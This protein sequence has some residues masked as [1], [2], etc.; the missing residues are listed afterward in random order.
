MLKIIAS[1]YGGSVIHVNSSSG[2]YVQ[3]VINNSFTIRTVILPLLNKYP[4][5]TSR[6]SLQLAFLIKAINGIT[7]KEY[8]DLRQSKY[9]NQDLFMPSFTLD[10]LPY[11]FSPWLGG[12]IEGK[13]CFL[14][15]SG[16]NIMNFSI[17]QL[18]DFYL[19]EAIR[20]YFDVEDLKISRK[21]QKSGYTLY[22][23]TIGSTAR[24]LRISMYCQSLLQ[25]YKYVQLAE[26]VSKAPRLNSIIQLFWF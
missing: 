4:P 18:H 13:G 19:I 10:S 1:V 17:S 25:G 9:A 11:Y 20:R 5:L 6:M 23:L 7:M 15:G 24:I 12:F 3:W 16:G 2:S 26:F 21:P 14:V 22:E 8:F